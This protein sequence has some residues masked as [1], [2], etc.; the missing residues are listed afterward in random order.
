M[1]GA[2]TVLHV[3]SFGDQLRTIEKTLI[4]QHI[5][6][7]ETGK[8]HTIL[9]LGGI[10]HEVLIQVLALTKPCLSLFQD[11]EGDNSAETDAGSKL[12]DHIYH[13]LLGGFCLV[14]LAI[15]PDLCCL[16]QFG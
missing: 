13:I 9:T 12:A 11:V 14:S 2:G 7:H 4:L 6:S 1:V 8:V 5:V 16:S 15:T 3:L 10:L